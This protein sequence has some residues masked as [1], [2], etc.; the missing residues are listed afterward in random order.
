MN[1]E[2][3]TISGSTCK[4]T[5]PSWSV[6]QL[7]LYLRRNEILVRQAIGKNACIYKKES[8]EAEELGV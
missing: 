3:Q 1:N 8:K 6:R 7:L 2:N 5:H 4:T